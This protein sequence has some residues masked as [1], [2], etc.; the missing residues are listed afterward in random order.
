M[1]FHV[2]VN[3]IA[4]L[5]QLT[6]ADINI[7]QDWLVNNLSVCVFNARNLVKLQGF[8][9]F[10]YSSGFCIV[11]ISGTGLI[12]SIWDDEI[13]PYVYAIY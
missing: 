13:L 5:N 9:S 8:Q 6:V 11:G 2:V 10:V 4:S 12:D 3:N 1:K 7:L